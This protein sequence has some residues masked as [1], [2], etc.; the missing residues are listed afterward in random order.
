M[1]AASLDMASGWTEAPHSSLTKRPFGVKAFAVERNPKR[2]VRCTLRTIFLHLTK[3]LLCFAS[4]CPRPSA[5]APR[6]AS[7]HPTSQPRLLP[8]C[9]ASAPRPQSRRQCRLTQREVRVRMWRVVASVVTQNSD[10]EIRPKQQVLLTPRQLAH[11]NTRASPTSSLRLSSRRSSR[12][13][14]E[15]SSHAMRA[16]LHLS[17]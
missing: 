1:S 2:A 15:L 9:S 14:L 13:T 8:S 6:L 5:T 12:C 11:N 10:G 4:H 7:P 16:R 17:S 3:N